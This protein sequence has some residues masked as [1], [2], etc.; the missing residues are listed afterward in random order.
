VTAAVLRKSIK[1]N[2]TKEKNPINRVGETVLIPVSTS[3][4]TVRTVRG[5]SLIYNPYLAVIIR[6]EE[7]I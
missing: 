2:T 1:P 6:E 7:I 4:T 3:H 5:G